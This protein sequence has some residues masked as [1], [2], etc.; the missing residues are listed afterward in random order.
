MT[1]L[2]ERGLKGGEAPLRVQLHRRNDLGHRSCDS[3]QL[4]GFE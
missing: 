2:S 1:P 4:M 3:N